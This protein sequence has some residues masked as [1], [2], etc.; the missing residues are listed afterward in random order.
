MKMHPK[1]WWEILKTSAQNFY[2]DKPFVYSSSIAYF[3]IFSVPAMAM[4]TVMIAGYF[5]EDD[6]VRREMLAQISQLTGQGSAQE[7]ER[8]MDKVSSTEGG[9]FTKFISLGTLLFSATTVFVTLQ[10]SINTIWKIKPKPERGVVKFIINRLLSL[11]MIGSLGFLILISL[12]ADALIVLFKNL[13]NEYLSSLAFVFIWFVNT[14][15]AAGII[16][17][18]FALIYKVLPDAKI[19]LKYVWTGSLLTTFL[20]FVGKYL[21][22][23]YLGNSDFTQ[24]Y[25]AAGSLVALLA[26]VYY[27]VLIVLFGAEFTYVYTRHRGGKITPSDQAVAI[28]IEEVEKEDHS[29]G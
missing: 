21:I 25:G 2:N 8:L 26:W 17:V 16:M 3:A 4:I 15:L 20:F 18:I 14:L 27:S 1:E 10:N 29:T 19:K 23:L 24:S 13:I 6:S 5:Y 28:T 7:V 12:V 9:A 22:G 11:A